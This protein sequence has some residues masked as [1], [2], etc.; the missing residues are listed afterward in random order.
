MDKVAIVDAEEFGRDKHRQISR[1]VV[2]TTT[3]KLNSRIL[4]NAMRRISSR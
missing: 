4:S 2:T 3:T 1:Q